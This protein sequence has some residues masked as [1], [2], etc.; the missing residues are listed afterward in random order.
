MPGPLKPSTPTRS[1][2]S[3]VRAAQ[4]IETRRRIRAAAEDLFLANGYVATS[5]DAIAKAAGVSRQTVFTA[6][7]SKA[8]LLS[9]IGDVQVVGDDQPIPLA[10]REVVKRLQDEDDPVALVRN[11]TKI[12]AGITERTSPTYQLMIEAAPH[13]PEVAKLKAKVDDLHLGGMRQM[14]DLLAAKGHLRRGRSHARA[15]EAAWLVMGFP[16]Y[17]AAM[18]KGWSPREYE[19]WAA[20]CLVAVLVEQDA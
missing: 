19:R 8:A 5:M 17:L 1:Y 10:E 13:D 20:E 15:A 12:G 7:G 11:W 2:T 16:A 18:A 6:F 4:A 9:E 3:D 14:V